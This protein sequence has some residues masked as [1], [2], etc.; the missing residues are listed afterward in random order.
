MGKRIIFFSETGHSCIFLLIDIFY[1][2]TPPY[3]YN[4]KIQNSFLC[5]IFYITLSQWKVTFY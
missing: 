1:E 2:E 4:I 3:K 5:H